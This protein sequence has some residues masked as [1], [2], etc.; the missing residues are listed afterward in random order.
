MTAPV[1]KAPAKAEKKLDPKPEPKFDP[2]TKE[3]KESSKTNYACEILVS[4]GSLADV[5]TAQAPNDAW[6]VKYIVDDKQ[7]LD[8]TRGTRTKLFD[9]YWDKFKEGLQSIEYG[10]G[11]V[12]PKLWGYQA[13]SLS[14]K[15]RR[16]G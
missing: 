15:K 12:S 6:V 9:M 16:K 13:A 4:N 2:W 8:L 1:G 11:T 14:K 3:E 7:C 10:K 5:H